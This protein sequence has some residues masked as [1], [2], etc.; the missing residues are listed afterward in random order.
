MSMSAFVPLIG[1]QEVQN[2]PTLLVGDVDPIAVG[3]GIIHNPI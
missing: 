2:E 3:I 1:G